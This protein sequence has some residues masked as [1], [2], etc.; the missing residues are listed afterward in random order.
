MKFLAL[1]NSYGARTQ[2]QIAWRQAFYFRDPQP[3]T[4]RLITLTLPGLKKVEPGPV[5]EWLS[6]HGEHGEALVSKSRRDLTEF[7]REHWEYTVL[8]DFLDAEN[9]ANFYW[10]TSQHFTLEEITRFES[11]H[12]PRAWEAARSVTAPPSDHD[13]RYEQLGEI[14]R[15]FHRTHGVAYGGINRVALE[16]NQAQEAADRARVAE[17]DA[18]GEHTIDEW[19]KFVH[20]VQSHGVRFQQLDRFGQRIADESHDAGEL[21]AILEKLVR[22][23]RQL[24]DTIAG[25]P[26]FWSPIVPW[27]SLPPTEV[28]K[29]IDVSN[30]YEVVA[31]LHFAVLTARRVGPI[32]PGRRAMLV[33][34]PKSGAEPTYIRADRRLLFEILERGGSIKKHGCTLT[35]D[36]NGTSIRPLLTQ[37]EELMVLA[38]LAPDAALE[39]IADLDLP[40][41]HLVFDAAK[42]A[43]EDHRWARIFADLLIELRTGLDA[44]IARRLVG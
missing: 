32:V 39:K 31:P 12:L 7:S 20:S 21:S 42:R 44:D 40:T 38:N 15:L 25:Y 14:E 37:V 36:A 24:T 23:H 29:T 3:D 22:D 34:A 41:D 5:R 35:A 8:D 26:S 17:F 10:H 43:T 6:K 11:T 30:A 19:A 4:N 16:R 28:G 13:A 2:V 27:L 1:T 33:P 9:Y 18:A